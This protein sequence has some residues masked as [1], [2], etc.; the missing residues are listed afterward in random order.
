MLDWIYFIPTNILFVPKFN[1]NI[2][3]KK[4]NRNLF[5]SPTVQCE[6]LGF[7]GSITFLTKKGGINHSSLVERPN[8]MGMPP[9]VIFPHY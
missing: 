8:F 3:G 6:G 1:G 5:K 7:V 4:L 9:L 2:W